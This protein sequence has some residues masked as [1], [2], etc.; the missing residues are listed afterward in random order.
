MNLNNVPAMP[1]QSYAPPNG[2]SGLSQSQMPNQSQ[3]PSSQEQ[4]GSWQK[5]V[6]RSKQTR[7]ITKQIINSRKDLEN[8]LANKNIQLLTSATEFQQTGNFIM[9]SYV[10]FL[11][12][13]NY[14]E[15]LFTFLQRYPQLQTAVEA[16]AQYLYPTS[17][18]LNVK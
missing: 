14:K 2:V 11:D 1:Q 10:V 3:A 15:S 7:A 9:S 17:K 18:D 8:Y 12:F 4:E 13:D 16:I 6:R 5:S